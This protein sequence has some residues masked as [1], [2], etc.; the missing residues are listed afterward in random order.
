MRVPALLAGLVAFAVAT[1]ALGAENVRCADP[2]RPECFAT[3]DA[4][5][6]EPGDFDRLELGA[7]TDTG[8][9]W[10]IPAG[11]TLAGEQ[12]T[13]LE[14]DM[15]VEAGASATRLAL[16]GALELSGRGS[17]LEVD[18]SVALADMGSLVSSTVSGPVSAGPGS[19][20][21]ESVLVRVVDGD[22]ITAACDA[23]TD[24][25][26]TARHVTLIG[27]RG[28]W[29]VRAV[30]AEAGR[31]AAV[32]L[33]NSVVAG[34]FAD[35]ALSEGVEPV[36]SRTDLETDPHLEA[37]GTPA[38]GSPL[39][40][41]GDPAPLTV[42]DPAAE[43]LED[44]AGRSRMADAD[45]DGTA[46]RDIGAMERPAAAFAL[47]AANLLSNP[48]AEAPDQQNPGRPAGWTGTL[49][50][51]TYGLFFTPTPETA[52]AAQAGSALFAG[53]VGTQASAKQVVD[54]S[55]SAPEIDA[56]GG[57]VELS[58]LLGGYRADADAGTVRAS[59]LDPQG[60]V[61]GSLTAGPVTAAERGN[62]INMLRR[63]AAADLPPL[64]R[65]IEVSLNAT[66]GGGA[67]TYI[68]AFFD[69]VSL[70]ATF[71][72]L[73]GT[74][75]V[76]P[77]PGPG[78]PP[79]GEPGP[80]Q[81]PPPRPF[82]GVSLLTAAAVI[83]RRGRVPLLVACASSTVRHCAG[84]LTLTT[85]PKNGRSAKR[86]GSATFTVGPGFIKRVRIALP[87]RWRDKLK[88]RKTLRLRLYAAARDGQGL[89]RATT[90]PLTL[91]SKKLRV[92]R[93]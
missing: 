81:P 88:R 2:Q 39:L 22:G 86:I 70:T 33:A 71:Q 50:R 32:E 68:D 6:A 75:P 7:F 63:S 30:C 4:A 61:L 11:V 69:N 36:F 64:T 23:V 13:I 3:L 85:A 27:E 76:D 17:R 84:V 34:E 62:A 89:S 31:T 74:G 47:P 53:G 93:R 14:G 72:P 77:G 44:A 67:G 18:G 15:D 92:S 48:G 60:A 57:A 55:A 91:R 25:T 19:A 87:S 21:L 54:V 56:G 46:R 40:D 37:D 9:P 90:S 8:G 73:P 59:F 16:T 26:L 29:G 80:G 83:D 45:A 52:L 49:V 12:G 51:E 58:A 10:T 38:S 65:R 43:A 66:H 79:P 28:G 35:G 1:P 41:A 78:Q 24:A 20:R 5:L 42:A 82:S